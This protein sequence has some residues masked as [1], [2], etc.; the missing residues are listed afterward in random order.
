VLGFRWSGGFGRGAWE[1]WWGPGGGGE[2]RGLQ[3]GSGLGG[4]RGPDA[5]L[6]WIHRLR[7]LLRGSGG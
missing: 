6:A 7:D 4:H 1:G 3:V 2:L 5:E